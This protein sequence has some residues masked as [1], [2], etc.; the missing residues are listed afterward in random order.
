MTT[1]EVLF[2][3]AHDILA[4]IPIRHLFQSLVACVDTAVG[5][6]QTGIEFEV[7]LVPTI[8]NFETLVKQPAS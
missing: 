2:V 8:S 7:V 3:Q 4:G 6:M 1:A 5:N